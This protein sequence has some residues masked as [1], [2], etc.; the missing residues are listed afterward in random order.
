MTPRIRRRAGFSLVE[1]L[2]ATAILLVIGGAAAT[3]LL[4]AFALWEHG[5]TR[6]RRLVATD[7]FLTSLRDFT[8]AQSGPASARLPAAS[9]DARVP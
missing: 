7:S 1:I 5:V 2:V 3:L 8:A 6:T 4:Q 9:S